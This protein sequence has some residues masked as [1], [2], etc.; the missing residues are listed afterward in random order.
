MFEPALPELRDRDGLEAERRRGADFELTVD[1]G[2]H[3]LGGV[4]V[5]ADAGPAASALFVVAEVP[6]GA[7]AIA[8][9]LADA[10]R[11]G[12]RHGV[13]G[14]SPRHK[15]PQ[16]PPQIRVSETASDMHKPA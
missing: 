2:R 6:D 3:L 4:A 9:H 15:T 10:E 16:T 5:G 12:F 13:T 8:Q 1:L 14:E 7:P 11:I